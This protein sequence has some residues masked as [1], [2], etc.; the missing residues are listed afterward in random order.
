MSFYTS[1]TSEQ[2]NVKDKKRKLTFDTYT[3][4]LLFFV[5][6]F[7]NKT[8]INAYCMTLFFLLLHSLLSVC[9]MPTMTSV[10]YRRNS[11]NLISLYDLETFSRCS[12]ENQTESNDVRSSKFLLEDLSNELL[13]DM[14]QYLSPYDLHHS[15]YNLNSRFNAICK[16]QKLRLDLS[17]SK[18]EFDYY[19]SNQQP[20]A[21]QIYS[22]KLDDN[23]DRLKIFNQ[24]MN[25]EFFSNLRTLIIREPSSD[26][27]G[28]K[29]YL[30]KTIHI[31]RFF[32]QIKSSQNYIDYPIYLI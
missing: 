23:Y 19:Y 27:L 24:Y 31:F 22:L 18:H 11:M 20:F 16:V 4:T 25:I 6:F 21:S 15:L 26:N 2:N 8:N 12:I 3:H 1:Y 13:I 5:L 29:F 17:E 32:F 14:F 10:L 9:R 30:N 7:L 28:S